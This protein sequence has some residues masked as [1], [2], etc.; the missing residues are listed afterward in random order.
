MTPIRIFPGR[1][2][3]KVAV[4]PSKSYQHRALICAAL[5]RGESEIAPVAASDDVRATVSAVRRLGA[6]CALY[7]NLLS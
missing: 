6:E 5:A 3:G 2:S 4:P 1:L 7:S